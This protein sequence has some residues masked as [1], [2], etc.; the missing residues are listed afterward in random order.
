MFPWFIINGIDFS[1]YWNFVP[2]SLTVT[3]LVSKSVCCVY[4]INEWQYFNKVDNNEMFG[5][6]LANLIYLRWIFNMIDLFLNPILAKFNNLITIHQYLNLAFHLVSSNAMKSLEY[7]VVWYTLDFW[8]WTS[9]NA[10][11]RY[12][13]YSTHHLSIL[14][15]FKNCIVARAEWQVCFF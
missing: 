3:I 12:I 15:S 2:S 14:T 1:N 6:T 13:Y 9:Q 7:K 10:F 11:L 5:K 8:M 4:D